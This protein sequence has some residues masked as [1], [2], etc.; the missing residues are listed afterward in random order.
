M[1]IAERSEIFEYAG[2]INNIVEEGCAPG[3]PVH[4]HVDDSE[5]IT[6]C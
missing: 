1:H 3:K 6:H 2:H 5:E 4:T